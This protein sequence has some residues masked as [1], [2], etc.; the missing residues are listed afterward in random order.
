[1]P[2]WFAFEV[3]RYVFIRKFPKQMHGQMADM[4]PV[5]SVLSIFISGTVSGRIRL[6]FQGHC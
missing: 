4:L 5:L 2:E 3:Q 6:F 1:M